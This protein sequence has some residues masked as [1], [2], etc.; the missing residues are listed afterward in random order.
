[1]D[2]SSNPNDFCPHRL[3]RSPDG[4]SKQKRSNN[5][6]LRTERL[7]RDIPGN[8]THH[9]GWGADREELRALAGLLGGPLAP[10]VGP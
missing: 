1:L 9:G 7:L 4:K 10:L 2:F 5:N 8:S 3:L 6:A